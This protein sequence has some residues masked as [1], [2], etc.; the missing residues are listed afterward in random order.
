MSRKHSYIPFLI[1]AALLL[2][3]IRFSA[4]EEFETWQ[5]EFTGMQ[6]VK[7]SGG[8]FQMGQ[9]STETRLLKKAMPY[10]QDYKKYYTDELPRH[11]VCVDDFWIGRQEVT[12]G[13]WKKVMGSNP[14][15]FNENNKLPMEKVSWFAA[16]R[17]MKKINERHEK[18]Y[19]RLPTEAEWEYAA[20]AGSE[21]PFHTGLTITTDQAN[22]NGIYTFGANLKGEYRKKTVPTGSFKP[23][24]FGLFDLHGNV[25]EWCSDWYDGDYYRSSTSKN[26]T[27]PE[28]GTMKVMRGGSWFHY[29][30]NIRSA[31]RYKNKPDGEYADTG[32]RVVRSSK[33]TAKPAAQRFDFD[34]DF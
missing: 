33:P 18:L 28:D 29:A 12:Q 15:H 16:Q 31:T 19:F 8:C 6:F 2:G 3:N 32:F 25:W 11:E 13:Q 20:R 17:F 23:N 7:I 26:P 5:E 21:T 27:G 1:L 14:A 9:T 30:G 4:A 24:D 10:E 22:F 34:P